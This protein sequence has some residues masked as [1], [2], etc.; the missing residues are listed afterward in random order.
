MQAEVARLQASF[1]DLQVQARALAA[2]PAG[3]GDVSAYKSLRNE[4]ARIRDEYRATVVSQG[5]FGVDSIK[6]K[7]ATE[8]FTKS[9]VKHKVGL[10]DLIKQRKT[11]NEVY[12]EQIAL[13]NM[14]A[15]GWS[16][17]G[18]G[19]IT[20]DL[21]IPNDLP[22]E[23]DS[24]S[25]KIGFYNKAINLASTNMINWG[26]NT[27]WAGRQLTV[28]LSVPLVMLAA[29]AGKTANE[30]D[31]QLTRIAKVY[32]TAYTGNLNATQAAIAKETELA[33]LR[34]SSMNL[35]TQAA[36]Q[37]GVAAKDTLSVEAELAATG[38]KGDALRRSTAEVVRISTLGE[39]DYQKA[40]ELSISLQNAYGLSTDQVTEKF[41]FL[42]SI[43]NAT[44]L[45]LQDM[46]E[47][48]PRAGAA[49]AGLG[50][51]VEQ[52]GILLVAMKEHGVDAAE[53]ANALKSATTRILKPTSDAID[54][55]NGLG[56]NI[57]KVADQAKGN[58]F[59]VLTELSKKLKDVDPYEAQKA[60][61]DLFGTYQFN[62]L[63]SA[64]KGITDAMG[65]VGDQAS[66]TARAIEVAGQSTADWAATA[67]GE[68]DQLAESA[69]G[70]L[71]RA[72]ETL[73]VELAK[74]GEP[75]L[76]WAA[77]GVEVLGKILNFLDSM[78]KGLKSFAGLA[79]LLIGLAGPT[80]M[81]VGLLAN[82]AGNA[83]KFGTT[84]IGL[85]KGFKVTN[86]EER[87][88]REVGIDIRTRLAAFLAS[89]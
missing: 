5:Q 4:L 24:L 37:Y 83:L 89:K 63:N 25:N 55:F 39:L 35:A 29:A 9:M 66:Q 76:L 7:S 81:L 21:I 88:A 47:A 46:V 49:L 28:G 20:A 85:A 57:E 64:L 43:E 18:R 45:S 65:G 19:Q 87:A 62:R 53:G 13:Q 80:I 30:V 84:L 41:N 79:A 11:L 10:I 17:N 22:R 42:N 3:V 56:I 72:F 58:L 44:S 54:R 32:D 15:V 60:I 27:Q 38:L 6:I 82:M 2:G 33:T 59:V 77:R 40:V 67:R 12:K 14:T 61:A 73:K 48:I 69:S 16:K 1:K 8:E 51:T 78:P 23:L 74:A 71:K 68:L 31:K 52:T 36:K 50:V 75:L 34:A 70:R 86:A 26:K